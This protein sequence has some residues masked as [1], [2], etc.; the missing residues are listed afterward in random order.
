[1]DDTIA[2]EVPNLMIGYRLTNY[3]AATSNS[4]EKRYEYYV[5]GA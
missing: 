5:E 1:M 4:D 3:G 2:A